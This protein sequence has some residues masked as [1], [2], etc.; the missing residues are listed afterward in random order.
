MTDKKKDTV[1]EQALVVIEIANAIVQESKS[2]DKI[3]K[4]RKSK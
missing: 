2:E 3:E 1:I 4:A